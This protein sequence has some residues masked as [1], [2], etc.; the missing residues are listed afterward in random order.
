MKRWLPAPVLSGFLFGLWL[1]LNASLDPG[2]LLLGAA[3][4]LA[5]PYLSAPLRPTPVHIRR[6]FVVLR[7]LAI[8][9]R[10]VVVSNVAIAVGVLRAGRNAPRSAFV[11][12]P[13]E[14]RDAN[15]LAAL[16]MITTIVPGTVWCELA[17]DRS[18][19]MLHVFNVHDQ[20]RFI[21]DYK[22][23]Y[24]LPLLEIFE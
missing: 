1:L 5:A 9:V 14:L 13:L 4:A 15:G 24:E 23:R 3:V 12:I 6:P 20:A 10:D 16:A 8:V 18:A 19:L 7:L 2:T 11:V 17:P 21:A 22:A